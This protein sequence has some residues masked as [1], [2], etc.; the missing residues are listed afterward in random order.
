MGVMENMLQDIPCP[1]MF[2]VRQHFDETKIEDV[3]AAIRQQLSKPEIDSTIKKG[4]RI[5]LTCSSRGI[6]NLAFIMRSVVRYCQEK[7]AEPFIVCAMG[8]HG[9]ACAEGQLEIA[10]TKGVTEEY[11][12]CPVTATMETVKIGETED[13]TP[14][15]MEKDA[16][17][18]DGIIVIGR[19]KAHSC[20][21]GPYESGIMKMMA[22]GLGKQYGAETCHNRGFGHMAEMIP[23]FAHCVLKNCKI[24]FG[25]AL[26]ENAY[27]KL[28]RVES[29]TPA[30]IPVKEPELLEDAKAH[31]ARIIPGSCDVLVVDYIGKEF[32]GD[33]MDPNIVGRGPQP[34][35]VG[36]FKEQMIAVLALTDASHGNAQGVG[37]ADITTRRLVDKIDYEAI[38]INSFT[39]C[40]SHSAPIPITMNSDKLAIQAAIKFCVDVDKSPEKLRVI[41]IQ[42]SL[43]MSEIELSEAYL[44]EV[45]NYPDMEV[46]SDLHEMPF[47]ENGNL[48]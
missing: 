31:M 6:D 22:I 2:K 14:V 24:L 28:Y 27:D 37:C 18:A 11:C 15:H 34:Y 25:L 41:R 5:A 43:A 29:M 44:D 4:M 47:D 20:F 23:Q 17:A 7:G 21:T 26:M 36:N 38:Y 48:F 30:E 3:D 40:N 12:G 32:S 16:A 13:G 46:I 35:K 8:S 39:S 9:N 10:R 33:G 19:V 45:K 42:N 1:K